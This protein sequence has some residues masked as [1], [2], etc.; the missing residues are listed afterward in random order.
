VPVAAAPTPAA[1]VAAALPAMVATQLAAISNRGPTKSVEIIDKKNPWSDFTLADGTVIRIRPDL[2][3]ASRELGKYNP[4]GQ[5]TYHF[6]VG[7]SVAIVAPPALMEGYRPSRRIKS[8]I[9]K[10]KK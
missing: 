9:K 3:N 1:E 10:K 7:V 2:V 6:S 4:Q 8:A 5:P